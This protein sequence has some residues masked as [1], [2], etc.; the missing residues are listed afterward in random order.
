MI[1]FG[2]RFRLVFLLSDCDAV[3][4]V[5]AILICYLSV[6]LVRTFSRVYV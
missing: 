2:S 1:V 4:A 3:T 5:A 6:M